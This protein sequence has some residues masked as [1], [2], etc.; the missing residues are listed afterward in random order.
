MADKKPLEKYEER[1]QLFRNAINH[2]HTS[3][4]PFHS[5]DGPWVILDAG[6]NVGDAYRDYEL[7]QQ[8][9]RRFIEKYNPDMTHVGCRNPFLLTEAFGGADSYFNEENINAVVEDL[10]DQSDYD[11]ILAGNFNRLLWE[12]VVFRKFPKAKDF[13]PQEM[14]DTCK[15]YKDL[16]DAKKTIRD[17]E[18]YEYGVVPV[19]EAKYYAF[20]FSEALFDYYR[21]I[22]GL[23]L[24]LRRVPQKVYDACEMMDAPMIESVTNAI[25]NEPKG[26]DKNYAMDVFTNMLVHSILNPK[27]FEQIVAKPLGKIFSVLEEYNRSSWNF[28]ESAYARFADFFGQY[29]KGV[30]SMCVES[31]DI[32]EL[33]KLMPNV[34]L[35]GGIQV[36]ILGNGT[37]EE[38]ID[39]VKKVIDTF[40]YEGGLVLQSN[41]ML[42]YRYDC[43]PE[44]LVAVSE[45]I[46][47]YRG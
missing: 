35:W 32:F 7:N 46:N 39:M 26:N 28:A 12:K 3:K 19:A 6:V 5:N 43:I 21:G 4:I 41:K 47:E 31:D 40:G 15:A 34:S 45:F 16:C 11:E 25:K 33:H 9:R 27:Q 38:C 13:T 1:L 14:A 10:L 37:K 44:N 42:A 36:D 23:S 30:V 24:D 17:M 20:Y 18:V 2:E 8:T 22:K 29:K